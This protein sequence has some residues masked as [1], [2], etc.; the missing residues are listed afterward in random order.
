MLALDG[1]NWRVHRW[2]RLGPPSTQPPRPEVAAEGGRILARIH[3]LDLA[4]GGPVVPWLTHRWGEAQWAQLAGAARAAVAVWADDFAAA[5]P[6]FLALDAVC[7]PRD[8]NPRA[9]L[10]KAW[11]AP[12]AVRLAGGDRLVAVGWEHAGAIPKDW[13][14]GSSLMA[15]SE[16]EADGYDPTAARAFLDGYRELADDIPITLPL[17]TS[18]VTAALNWTVSRANIALNGDD[19]AQREVA[20]RTIRAL[21]RHPVGLDDIRRLADALA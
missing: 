20:E 6:G 17:F 19:P 12:N 5:V 18:G 1:T 10:S 8:P 2:A 9:V 3:G 4:P 7:D 16:T 15:W 21:S 13:D 14:L 11:H